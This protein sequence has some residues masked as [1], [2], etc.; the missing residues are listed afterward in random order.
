MLSQK[1]WQARRDSNPQHPDL[2]SDAL[3][4][5]LLACMGESSKTLS[6]ISLITLFGFL[7]QR[8]FATESAVFIEAQ[9]IR[10]RPFV[11]RGCIISS[12]AFST[13]KGNYNSHQ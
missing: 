6:R 4:L 10:C 3:P 2:E 1:G 11:L 13:C 12:F 9:L 8:V 7:V 5:E